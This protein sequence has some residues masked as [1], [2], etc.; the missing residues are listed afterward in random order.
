MPTLRSIQ[1]LRAFAAFSVA[2]FHAFQWARLDFDIGGAGV[3]IFFVISGFIMWR[4][5]QD[6]PMA[7]LEFLRRR[8]VRI[9]PLYWTVSLGLAAAALLWPARF[10]DT[11]PELGHVLK[12]LAFLQHRNPAGLPF[13]IL[14]PGWTLNYEAVFYLIFAACLALPR[15]SR[16]LALTCGLL[17]LGL[18][19]FFYPPAYEMLANPLV[20][21]FLAGVL[22][23]RAMSWGFALGRNLG[24]T[25]MAVALCCYGVMWATRSE[26]DL[27]R[28]MVWGLPALLLVM[29][30]TAVE[31]DGGLPELPP[32]RA[33]GDA[34]Y[35]LYLTHPL[36]IGALAVV[37][38]TWRPWLFIPLALVLASVGGW[39]CWW[40][41]ERPVTAGLKGPLPDAASGAHTA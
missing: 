26:W 17:S 37:M 31:A 10:P 21:E 1:Y 4:T 30:L 7:P 3:D 9:I 18:F 29:G 11:Y 41:F 40:L 38:G 34:S 20:L 39:L 6:R 15:E 33:L 35:S 36:I 16:L 22:L 32:I 14:P 25:A 2:A 13:P 27:W 24:W 12:S 5:T 19:G 8:A 23:A 28:P